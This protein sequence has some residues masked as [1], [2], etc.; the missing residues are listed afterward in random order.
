[1]FAPVLA[2]NGGGA[3]VN[4]LSVLSWLALP[5]TGTYSASKAAA[6]SFTH[7]S[8]AELGEQG[9]HVVAVHV[10][11]MDT[12][13]AA[14]VEGPSP[15]PRT[16]AGRCSTPSSPVGRRSSRTSSAAG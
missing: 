14:E 10:G 6:W 13:M 1:V 15:T 11:Y 7:S 9:T 8:R 4:V 16:W 3:V 12:D 5:S 2:R